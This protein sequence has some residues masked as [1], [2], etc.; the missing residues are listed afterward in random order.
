MTQK[1]ANKIINDINISMKMEGMELT[2][3]D[4]ERLSN[5]ITGKTDAKDVMKELLMKYNKPV[6]AV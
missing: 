4:K 6:K 5:C 3:K 1:N 2:S